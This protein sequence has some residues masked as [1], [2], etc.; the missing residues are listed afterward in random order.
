MTGRST[1]LVTGAS[2]GIG[3]ATAVALARRGFRVI[4]HGRDAEALARTARAVEGTAVTADLARPAEVERLAERVLEIAGGHLDV[5]VH[6]AGAG[7]S[8]AFPEMDPEATH[9]VLA[10]NLTAPIALTRLLL[11]AVPG[12]GHL[13]FVTSIAGRLGVAGEAVYSAAKAGLDTF[14]E[15]LRGELRGT[16]VRVGVVVPGVV[17]TP[18]FE[19]RGMPYARQRPKPIP[20]SEVAEA[21][22][23]CVETGA[24]E[25]YAP[26][27]LRVPVA[28]RG[29]VPGVYRRLE[30]RFGADQD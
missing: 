11:P 7:W 23:R 25:V 30:A 12:G 26:R 27:W 29:L 9:R 6:N 5:V 2:S 16:G 1:A 13:V 21:V 19:R 10:V 28:V 15:S 3:R 24:A 17:D 8:G 14:A 20:A 18:F 22:M 4:V